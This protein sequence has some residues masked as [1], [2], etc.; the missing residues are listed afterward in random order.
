MADKE[1]VASPLGTALH[2]LSPRDTVDIQ[3]TAVPQSFVMNHCVNLLSPM[4]ACLGRKLDCTCI[5]EGIFLIVKSDRVFL[6]RCHIKPE[7]FS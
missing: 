7:E 1:R 5:T 6:P 4:F 2:R 3:T